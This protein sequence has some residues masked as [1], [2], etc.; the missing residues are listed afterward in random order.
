MRPADRLEPRMKRHRAASI[1][2]LLRVLAVVFVCDNAAAVTFANTTPIKMPGPNCTD[3]DPA[4]P[5]PVQHRRERTERHHLRR[6]RAVAR[7]HAT[8]EGDIEVLLVGPGGGTRN[9][10]IL[11]DAGTGASNNATVT[12]DD[13]AAS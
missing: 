11:S 5:Y 7:H 2:T 3:S 9:I 13:A 10:T 6:E 1:V 4:N 8:F 12:F